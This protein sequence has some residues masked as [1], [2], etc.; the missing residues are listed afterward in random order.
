MLC[1]SCSISCRSLRRSYYRTR[2]PLL[3]VGLQLFAH[4]TGHRL[5]GKRFRR[6][7]Q[8]VEVGVVF[9]TEAVAVDEIAGGGIVA[10]IAGQEIL[11][12]LRLALD[13]GGI[14]LQLAI[15]HV[16]ADLE[17]RTLGR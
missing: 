14:R 16:A 5:L 13:E 2:G 6:N 4:N 10:D 17:C 9:L 12:L 15:E 7:I 8:R 11:R 3:G 1:A